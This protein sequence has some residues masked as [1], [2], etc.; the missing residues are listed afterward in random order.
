MINFKALDQVPLLFYIL[1]LKTLVLCLGFAGVKIYQRRKVEND[2]KME[3]AEKKKLAQQTLI[4]SLK[5]EE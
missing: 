3:Q 5:K 1:A 4:D 2:L